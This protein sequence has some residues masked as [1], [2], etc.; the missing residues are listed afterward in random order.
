MADGREAGT[1]AQGDEGEGDSKGS[2]EPGS[3]LQA[4]DGSMAAARARAALAKEVAEG[5]D[6]ADGDAARS[7]CGGGVEAEAGGDAFDEFGD[8]KFDP[9]V[10]YQTV[11]FDKAGQLRVLEA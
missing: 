2:E 4:G 3:T 1:I 10:S 8:L 7:A 5:V 9:A 11:E 6:E